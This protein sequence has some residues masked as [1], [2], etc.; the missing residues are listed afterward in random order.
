[1]SAYVQLD[2]PP[3]AGQL[4]LWGLSGFSWYGLIMWP[5]QCIYYRDG[6]HVRGVI[7]CLA[8]VEAKHVR[9]VDGIDY[10]QIDRVTLGKE[11]KFW[12]APLPFGRTH[13]SDMYAGI[14]SGEKVSAPPGVE[15]L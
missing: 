14:I 5:E 10:R 13:A 12:S 2:I 15:W 6:K 1:M 11:S 3:H 9:Q 4:R 7:N 8:W